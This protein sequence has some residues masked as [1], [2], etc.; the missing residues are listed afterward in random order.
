MLHQ[1]VALIVYVGKTREEDEYSLYLVINGNLD[2][3]YKPMLMKYL[4]FKQFPPY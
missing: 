4:L 2:L 1:V 3:H